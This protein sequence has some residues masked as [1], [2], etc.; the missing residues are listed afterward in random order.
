MAKRKL[1]LG[2]P[3]TEPYLSQIK[4]TFQI[5]PFSQLVTPGSWPDEKDVRDVCAGSEVIILEADRIG[6]ETLK[7]WR[8]AGLQ[9]L[10]C[11]RGNPVNIDAEACRRLGIMLTYTPGRNAQ[12][13][14]E[15]TFALLLMLCKQLHRSIRQIWNGSALDTSVNDILAVPNVAD[16]VWMNERINVYNTVPLGCELYEKTLSLIGF[17]A[18]AKRVARIA[19]G[20]SMHV[21]AYD[22]FCPPE[23]FAAYGAES[24][25]LEEAL[26]RGDFV[27]VHLPVLP[28][29]VGMIDSVCFDRM[30]PGAMFINTARAKVVD[31]RAMIE[32]LMQ[33]KIAGAAVDV[34]W[35][36]PCPANHPFLTMDNVIVSPHQAGATVDIDTWQSRLAFE[37][38]EAFLHGQ[39]CPH[40][41]RG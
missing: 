28:S 5:T 21:L 7:A 19:A 39:S 33:K 41:Y 8:D 9:L 23:A 12:S 24:C 4:E 37:D 13:V 31:Q 6:E 30:K 3:I 27:S 35:Q 22:P 1:A 26:S 16:V 20:F 32:A 25:T 17:G 10:I 14:A 40:I 15:Y 29:T 2:T 11:T 36:E 18:V 34:M 38:L